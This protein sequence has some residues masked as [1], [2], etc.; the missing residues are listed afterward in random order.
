MTSKKAKRQQQKPPEGLV[1][2]RLIKAL[3]HPLRTR[4][5]SILN[6]RVSSPSDLAEEL[7]KSV[8]DT[9][10]HV[11]VLKEMGFIE[12]VDTKPRRGAVEHYYRGIHRALIPPGAWEKLPTNIQQNIAADTFRLIM[13]DANDAL[14]ADTYSIRPDSHVSWTPM[15]L[16]EMGWG[17]FISLLAHTLEKAF[18]IQAEATA[19]LMES[20]TDD[21]DPIS[22]TMA[23][24][25]FQSIRGPEGEM[26]TSATK[27]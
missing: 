4:I 2:Q 24:A 26:K 17:A 7:S 11:K 15:I 13:S 16:D 18:D 10:Y 27:R 23:L 22:V 25:G 19:R 9:S 21:G 14:E 3:G 6:E 5:L 1:D 20:K 12:M 8:G